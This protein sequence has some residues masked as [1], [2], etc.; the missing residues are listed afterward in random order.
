MWGIMSPPKIRNPQY[1]P[2]SGTVL[3]DRIFK[4]GIKLQS[5]QRGGSLIQHGVP[6]RRVA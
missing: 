5:V 2:Q 3:R 1:L 6:I 4:G